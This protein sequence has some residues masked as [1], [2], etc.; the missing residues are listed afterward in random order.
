MPC[1]HESCAVAEALEVCL[2]CGH[3]FCAN[4]RAEQDGLPAC[5]GC[6]KAAHQQ[7]QAR[8]AQAAAAPAVAG[9]AAVSSDS[10]AG[11]IQVQVP[12]PRPLPE[13]PRWISPLAAF[14]ALPA[15]GYTWWF[16]GWLSG[17]HDLPG[18]VQ[19]AGTALAALT[20][21][22]GVWVIAKSR[23]SPAAPE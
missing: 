21:F 5:T 4:H 1:T 22:G 9:R 20:V 7:K 12:P 17:R 23:L 10:G 8:A 13:A 19:P 15:A 18:W 11:P 16:V 3:A 14:A 6:L 2:F